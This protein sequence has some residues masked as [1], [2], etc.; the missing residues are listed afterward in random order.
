MSRFIKE[1]KLDE[2]TGPPSEAEI[3]TPK[4][5][6]ANLKALL[7]NKPPQDLTQT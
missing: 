7:N 2:G 1:M 3:I 6:L 4:N 5:R